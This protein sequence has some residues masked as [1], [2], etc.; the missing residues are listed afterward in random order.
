MKKIILFFAAAML[1][2]GCGTKKADA[3]AVKVDLKAEY[4]RIYSEAEK[5]FY[6]AE[7][8]EQGMKIYEDFLDASYNFLLENLGAPY[9]DTLF[10]QLSS[11][12]SLEQRNTLFEQMPQNM[13][14]NPLIAEQ[15]QYFMA[16]K[17]TSKGAQYIDFAATTPEGKK[18][19]LSELIGKTDYVLVD[20]WASWCGP[21]RRLIPV[22]KE[23][24][25][26]QPKGHFQIV[27]CS[28]D[29]DENAWRKALKEE[30]MPWP[31][32]REEDDRFGSEQYAIQHIPTT[33][34]IDKNGVI[35]AREPSESELEE[36]LKK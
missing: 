35:I 26:A 5:A 17:K 36:L 27:S 14:E 24:Y 23:I 2:V 6:M 9:S 34:L 3:E 12:L 1:I 11:M 29:K 7:N 8:E 28:I 22:L 13:Q 30:Q 19:A 10:A 25:A 21:C 4:E 33:I 18:L 16:E 20:F 31:Q 15:Y 32:M